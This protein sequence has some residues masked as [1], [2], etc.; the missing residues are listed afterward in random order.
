MYQRHPPSSTAHGER[1]VTEVLGAI[2]VF[3]LVLAVLALVQVSGIP[4]ANEQVEF[5]HSQRV[6]GDFQALD[7]S[8]DAAGTRGSL[9]STGVEAGVRYPNRLFFVNP[10]PVGGSLTS[11]SGQ[12]VLLSGFSGTAADEAQDYDLS[13][14]SFTTTSLKYEAAYN[15][16][17]N[18]PELYYENGVVFERYDGEDVIVD[19]GTVVSGRRI[20][21][22]T[23]DGEFSTQVPDELPINVVPV[24]TSTRAVSVTATDAN[25][26]V[27]TQLSEDTWGTILG[28]ESRVT[29][30]SCRDDAVP[31]DERC[32][33]LLDI[34]LQNGVYDLRM[35]KVGLTTNDN[36][37]PAADFDE[38][39]ARYIVAGT[40]T[41]TSA[42]VGQTVE[43]SAEVRD[44]YN[45][46]ISGESVTFS[47]TS[48]D[49]S[50]PSPGPEESGV[51]GR[52]SKLVSTAGADADTPITVEAVVDGATTSDGTEKV[53]FTV[54]LID[55]SGSGGGGGGDGGVDINP[56]VNPDDGGNMVLVDV[57]QNSTGNGNNEVTDYV[58]TFK[59]TGDTSRSIDELRYSFA[60]AA[61]PSGADVPTE[62]VV[63][64]DMPGQKTLTLGGAYATVDSDVASKDETVVLTL[65]PTAG[66]KAFDGFLV[67]TA[68]IDAD[69]E[70][71]SA[72]YFVDES[73][74]DDS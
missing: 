64:G 27:R 62:L 3:G 4:A 10:G 29:G 13:S 74:T 65:T 21:L 7:A 23:V 55:G 58:L 22:V 11:E 53:V 15:E 30:I 72:I 54:E 45:N 44:R 6:A 60:F 31:S 24:S 28:S 39:T 66:E 69:G 2:L 67:L 47:V 59:N 8:I 43:L 51:D 16:Y 68:N 42:V 26:T 71:E 19:A 46:P 32:N 5:E 25:I 50:I 12:E 18:A 63:S 17:A 61:G 37:N 52:V 36:Q 49:G 73:I 34:S 41:S 48:T 56:N 40:V 20:T 38:E 14:E 35:A 57:T 1:A 70:R 33:G 9:G